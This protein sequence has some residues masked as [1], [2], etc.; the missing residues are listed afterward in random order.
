MCRT[1]ISRF[2]LSNRLQS[3]F[4]SYT[5][6]RASGVGKPHPYQPQETTSLNKYGLPY[7][8]KPGVKYTYIP[9]KWIWLGLFTVLG[10]EYVLWLYLEAQRRKEQGLNQQTFI[11]FKLIDKEHI[12]STCSIFTLRPLSKPKNTDI[13]LQAWN[14]GIWSVELKQPQLQISRFYTPLPSIPAE[15]EET[16]DLH[17]LVRREEAGEVSNYL[18]KLDTGSLLELRGPK[19]EYEIPDEVN[20]ILFIAGGTGI[21]PAL[22]ARYNLSR[23]KATTSDKS[24]KILWANRRAEDIE[25]LEKEAFVQTYLDL[26]CSNPDGEHKVTRTPKSYHGVRKVE[27]T[28]QRE[29]TE[30]QCYVDEEYTWITENIIRSHFSELSKNV[31]LGKVLV[32]VSGPDGLISYLAGP[33]L[34]ARGVQQQGELGGLLEKTIPES[35]KVWKL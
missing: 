16:A 14:K 28:Q 5:R 29:S 31:D 18:H 8:L 21:A 35:C 19:I 11:P 10:S 32:M 13:Y 17:F 27:G 20:T 15:N 3:R 4:L 7:K 12:S 24:V 30:V 2:R 6:A 23:R 9:Y 33:K 34:W 25:F 22:Q 26:H 1:Y